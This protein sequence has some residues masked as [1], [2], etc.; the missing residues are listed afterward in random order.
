MG[1]TL[2]DKLVIVVTHNAEYFNE[3]ASRK[4]RIHDGSIVGDEETK[5]VEKVESVM[6]GER[7]PR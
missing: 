6:G 7:I 4:V 3:Y 2:K 1:S 5:K